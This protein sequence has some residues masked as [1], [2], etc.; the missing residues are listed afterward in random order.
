VDRVVGRHVVGRGNS[1]GQVIE[2]P[3]KVVQVE[4][5]EHVMLKTFRMAMY[6]VMEWRPTIAEGT[7]ALQD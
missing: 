4:E 5:N 6:Q 3:P 7:G 1:S 2:A